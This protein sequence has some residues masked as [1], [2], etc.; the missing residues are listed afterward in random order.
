MQHME[1]DSTANPA[2]LEDEQRIELS[3]KIKEEANKLFVGVF[4]F[5]YLCLFR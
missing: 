4:F 1:A 5:L 3:E 2:S